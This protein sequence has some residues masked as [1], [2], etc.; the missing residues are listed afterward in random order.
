MLLKCFLDDSVTV[1]NRARGGR[2][3]KSFIA[4]G[5]LDALAGQTSP[6]DT[7]LIQFG[8]NDATVSKPERYASPA[9]YRTNLMRFITMVREKK[10]YPVLLTPVAQR[11]FKDGVLGESH[12]P[13][14]DAVRDLARETNTPLVDLDADSREYFQA[15]GEEGSKKYFLQYTPEDHVPRY[16]DG[17][18]DNTHFNE[19]GARVVAALVARRLRELTIPLSG[20]VRPVDLNTI[21]AVGTP[22]CSR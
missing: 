8:H 7:V 17:I 6:G 3:T 9:D 2:S 4:E 18:S 21:M 1:D 16:P 19:L 22:S 15:A 12:G 5:L 11:T 20:H 14:S 13:Y 10:A